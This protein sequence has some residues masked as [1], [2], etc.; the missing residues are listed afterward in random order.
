MKILII[1]DEIQSRKKV[2]DYI[3]RYDPSINIVL[4]TGSFKEA[5]HTLI[6]HSIDLVLSDI[7]ILD[8]NVFDLLT[9]TPVVCP[10]IF[11]SAY[12]HYS[13]NALENHGFGYLL[14]PYTYE[15]FSKVMA[16]YFTLKTK[17][18]GTNERNIEALQIFRDPDYRKRIVVQS[19]KGKVSIL[20]VNLVKLIEI[21]GGVLFAHT[22]S[23]KKFI[24]KETLT[25]SH[26]E[27]TL[28]PKMFFRINK[29]QLINIE[30]I[31]MYEQ[32]GKNKVAIKLT[33]NKNS[34]LITSVNRTPLF[35][36][37]VRK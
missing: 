8:G 5:I 22:E 10:F 37:W 13:F 2:E 7:E 28:S 3:K 31:S 24:I 12:D 23:D 19:G 17:I 32:Y 14:K 15:Q 18:S 27:A 4:S 29:S 36:D 1:E 11:I 21:E 9:K 26:I 35:K 30:F 33:G 6:N 20:K 25:L 34:T 16:N